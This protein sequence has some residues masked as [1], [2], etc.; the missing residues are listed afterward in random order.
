MRLKEETEWKSVVDASRN[1]DF[2]NIISS[3]PH[4]P[5]TRLRQTQPPLSQILPQ[6]RFNYLAQR[7]TCMSFREFSMLFVHNRKF[8]YQILK[9]DD[10]QPLLWITPW[11][12]Q[13]QYLH[14]LTGIMLISNLIHPCYH[15]KKASCKVETQSS[16]KMTM[17]AKHR[18]WNKCS[19]PI[20]GVEWPCLQEL[21]ETAY[22]GSSSQLAMLETHARRDSLSEAW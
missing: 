11:R 20:S 10:S 13:R 9:N 15:H 18:K 21:K 22:C 2:M 4:T 12:R 19:V 5:R 16:Q 6:Q 8:E 17:L 7:L 14:L 1:D 3:L